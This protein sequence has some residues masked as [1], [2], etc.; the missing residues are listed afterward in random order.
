MTEDI[1]QGITQFLKELRNEVGP[2]DD[3]CTYL[4]VHHHGVFWDG[5][6]FDGITLAA[7]YG[8]VE[9]VFGFETSYGLLWW[10][11]DKL[12]RPEEIWS[13]TLPKLCTMATS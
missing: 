2:L 7:T 5:R 8:C 9:G 11:R 10:L 12:W 3:S 4:L 13:Q 6:L 1:I